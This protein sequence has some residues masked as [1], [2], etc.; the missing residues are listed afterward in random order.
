ML[1]VYLAYSIYFR[2]PHFS[3]VGLNGQHDMSPYLI[4]ISATAVLLIALQIIYFKLFM[5]NT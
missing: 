3:L 4:I 1:Q 2:R 5:K